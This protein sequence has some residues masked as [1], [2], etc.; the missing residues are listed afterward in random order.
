MTQAEKKKVIKRLAQFKQDYNFTSKQIAEKLQTTESAVSHWFNEDSLPRA[1]KVED[2][3][4]LF[5]NYCIPGII[6]IP[7][8]KHWSAWFFIQVD[9]IKNPYGSWCEDRFSGEDP[10]DFSKWIEDWKKEFPHPEVY[11]QYEPGNW[12]RS[13]AHLDYLNLNTTIEF[14]EYFIGHSSLQE[15]FSI[16]K[17][18]NPSAF[19]YQLV[20]A[21]MRG[22]V[23]GAS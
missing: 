13:R 4:K 20:E 22:E 21:L 10:Q 12:G 23:D 15:V 5:E 11:R 8:N 9:D 6:K 2:I 16:Y 1:N 18:M 14:R 7:K 3:Y 17:G 19:D